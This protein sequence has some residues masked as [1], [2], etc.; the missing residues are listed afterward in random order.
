[1]T[2][3]LTIEEALD[4]IDDIEYRQHLLNDWELNFLE[5]IRFWGGPMLTEK[6]S[7]CLCR[8]Y[9]KVMI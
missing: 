4:L 8:V 7:E 1:V 5:S 9:D 2:N 6:Q 3:E